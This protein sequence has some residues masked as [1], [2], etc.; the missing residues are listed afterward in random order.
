VIDY[1]IIVLDPEQCTNM[2]GTDDTVL[3]ERRAAMVSTQSQHRSR[4]KWWIDTTSC[5]RAIGGRTGALLSKNIDRAVKS[6][7]AFVSEYARSLVLGI[8]G[9]HTAQRQAL[10]T[11]S[12]WSCACLCPCAMCV[13]QVRAFLP[14]PLAAGCEQ[15]PRLIAVRR[16]GVVLYI[17]YRYRHV[18]CRY[19]HGPGAWRRGAIAGGGMGF[20]VQGAASLHQ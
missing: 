15:S 20:G 5:A 16:Y 9:C 2:V 4:K 19:R 11:K 18:H 6:L 3:L 7:H 10:S 13:W 14:P 1:E 12:K 8:S 17:W